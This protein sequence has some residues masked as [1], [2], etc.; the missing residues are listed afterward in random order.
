MSDYVHPFKTTAKSI[1]LIAEIS[2]Q[3][4]RYA[5]RKGAALEVAPGVTSEVARLWSMFRRSEELTGK[6]LQD[7]LRLKD[8]KNFRQ[9]YLLPALTVRQLEMT[10]PDKPNSRL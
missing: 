3:L 2:V 4:E 8:D 1:T 5:I 6:E 10:V 7:R 9:K